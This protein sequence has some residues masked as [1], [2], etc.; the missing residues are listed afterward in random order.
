MSADELELGE[1]EDGP[2]DRLPG[3]FLRVKG[4]G[5]PRVLRADGSGKRDTYGRPSGLYRGNTIGLER[6]QQQ[7]LLIGLNLMLAEGEAIDGAPD[8]VV[9]RAFELARTGLAAERGTFVHGDLEAVHGVRDVEHA[10]RNVMAELD[11]LGFSPELVEAWRLAYART[12]E[13][14]QLEILATEAKCCHDL[15]RVAGSTDAFM[16]AHEDLVFDDGGVI[17][18]DEVVCEDHKTGQL[19]I[20]AGRPSHWLG[21]AA[22]IAAYA[23]SVH[24]VIGDGDDPDEHR[25][26]WPWEVNQRS[27]LILHFDLLG[28]LDTDVFTVR[29]VRVDLGRGHDLGRYAVLGR[30]LDRS[31]RAFGFHTEPP[32]AVTVDIP[33]PSQL[34]QQL[35]ASLEALGIPVPA[36]APPVIPISGIAPVDELRQWLQDRVD[37]CGA[38]PRAKADLARRWPATVAPLRR[39]LDHTIDELAAI[40]AVL[41]DVEAAHTIPFGPTRPGAPKGGDGWLSQLLTTFPGSTIHTKGAPS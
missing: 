34:E 7:Q 16:L 40:E 28:A 31:T 25:E 19:R 17:P 3:D 39:S 38:H 24:Y 14:L 37:V 21:Y 30:E 36:E 20:V 41:D 5:A 26:P 11:R 6:W 32:T 35:A 1:I 22:Q 23:S 27:G 10:E 13:R 2:S 29:P 9:R 33:G 15:W 18:A 4:S 12:L 8:K